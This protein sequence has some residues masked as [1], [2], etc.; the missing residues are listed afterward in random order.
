LALKYEGLIVHDDVT[1]PCHT[2]IHELNAH[3]SACHTRREEINASRNLSLGE[4]LYSSEET[5]A[6]F[7]PSICQSLLSRTF[8]SLSCPWH[9]NDF[10]CSTL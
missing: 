10:D 2:S 6:L 5:I 4:V 1:M 9:K 7:L 8:Q 3:L